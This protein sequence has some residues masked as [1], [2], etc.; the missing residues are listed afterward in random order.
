MT[1]SAS[2]PPSPDP[3]KR[4]AQLHERAASLLAQ[5]KHQRAEAAGRQALGILEQVGGTDHPAV[6]HVLLT[7]G[8]IVEAKGDYPAAE[9]CYE[10]A[11]RILNRLR[12]DPAWQKLRLQALNRLA[13]IHRVQ[14]RYARAERIF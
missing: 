8:N 13:T 2:K 7:L 10:R 1:M 4:A 11:V 3:W 14:G 12:R 9:A 6:A 5:S